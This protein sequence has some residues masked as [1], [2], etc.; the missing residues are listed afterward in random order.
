MIRKKMLFKFITVIFLSISPLMASTN[1]T[2]NPYSVFDERIYDQST[3]FSIKPNFECLNDEGY[4]SAVL[5]HF[6][7]KKIRQLEENLFS[8]YDKELEYLNYLSEKYKPSIASKLMGGA[9]QFLAAAA[10]LG[11]LAIPGVE[12]VANENFYCCWC[13]CRSCRSWNEHSTRVFE[14]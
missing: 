9:G 13:S 8:I 4:Q 2:Q 12:E 14:A 5:R 10:V 1:T 7:H 6:T 11:I 3:L